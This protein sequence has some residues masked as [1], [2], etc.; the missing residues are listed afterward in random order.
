MARVSLGST[1]SSTKQPKSQ[2]RP[3]SKI[4]IKRKKY[5][6]S[7]KSR[8]HKKGSSS[9]PLPNPLLSQSLVIQS[10]PKAF[11]CGDN[12]GEEPPG[13]SNNFFST[14]NPMLSIDDNGN[15]RLMETASF[16]G[17]NPAA[18]L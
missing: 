2:E 1:H 12:Q 13:V 8:H 3:F 10:E 9:P 7:R 16:I 17:T 14:Q 5:R 4:T 15:V 18:P 11:E 6:P